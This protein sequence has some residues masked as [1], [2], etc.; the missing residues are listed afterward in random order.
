MREVQT[1][2]WRWEARRPRGRKARSRPE[3]SSYAIDDGDRLLLFDPLAPPSEIDELAAERQR[4]A[5][6]LDE[7]MARARRLSLAERLDAPLYVPPPDDSNPNP[8][9]DSVAGGR[10]PVGVEAFQGMEPNDPRALG[11]PPR[12]SSSAIRS[13]TA[14]TA[15]SSRPTGRTRACRPGSPRGAAPLLKLPVELVLATH[16]GP[17]DRAALWNAALLTPN[18]AAGQDHHQNLDKPTAIRR[19]TNLPEDRARSRHSSVSRRGLRSEHACLIRV[20]V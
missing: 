8:L 6:V 7:P 9:E 12:R 5:I 20:V 4:T 19:A 14:A 13:S 15:S 17:T 18:P 3:V 2:L 10:L 11:R 1:G 16:R